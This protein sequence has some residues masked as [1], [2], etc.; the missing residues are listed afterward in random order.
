MKRLPGLR[1]ERAKTRQVRVISIT[2]MTRL[3]VNR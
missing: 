2:L 1:V 3:M